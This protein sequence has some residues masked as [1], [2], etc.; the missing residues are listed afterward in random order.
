MKLLIVGVQLLTFWNL[1][2]QTS[3]KNWEILPPLSIDLVLSGNF[4]ELRSSSFHTGLDFKTQQKENFPVFAVDDGYISRVVISK[5]GY[6]KAIYITHKNG[7]TTVYAHLRNFYS[8]LYEFVKSKQYQMKSYEVNLYLPE[9][10]FIIKKGQVIGY[11]G[12]TGNSFGPHLHFEVRKKE[13]ETLNPL[14]LFSTIKDMFYP[15]IKNICFY[16]IDENICNFQ[17]GE[18]KFCISPEIKKGKYFIKDTIN[19]YGKIGFGI[20]GYDNINSINQCG[21]YSIELFVNNNKIYHIQFDKLA[22]SEQKF[23][24]GFID[25]ESNVKEKKQIYK[26]FVEP[27]INLNIYKYISNNGIL[28][29]YKEGEI[30]LI[31]IVAKD[32]SRKQAV[33]EFYVKTMK[34]N[35]N[36]K[37]KIYLNIY[38]YFDSVSYKKDYT[39]YLD[40]FYVFIPSFSLFNNICF[41]YKKHINNEYLSNIHEICKSYIPLKE[42]ITIGIMSSKYFDNEDRILMAE[43]FNNKIVKVYKTEKIKNNFYKAEV[44]NFGE[45]A[46]VIDTIPPIC[47]PENLSSSLLYKDNDTISFTVKD[48]MSDISKYEA[49]IDN[50]WALLE[51]DLKKNKMFYVVDKSRLIRNKKHSMIINLEDIAGNKSSFEYFFNY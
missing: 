11:S 45:Y 51:Y 7:Y 41:T 49:L 15:I 44:N 6:G 37:E 9:D 25:Y 29:F 34:N 26:L 12:N 32:I 35:K 36:D 16:K 42:K 33:I 13:E 39:I 30:N 40:E 23:Y 8:D 14:P 1:F 24:K 4:G 18:N 50:K 28:E 22:F 46:L 20:E 47:I 2:S 43:I 27:N 38:D 17:S 19:V 5:S 10:K 3:I 21:I 31:K 48:N